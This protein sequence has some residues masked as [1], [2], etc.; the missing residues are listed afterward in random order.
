MSEYIICLDA[1]GD[2]LKET[3]LEN[4]IAFVPMEYSIGEEMRTSHGCESEELLKRFYDGQRCISESVDFLHHE[5]IG[6]Q[7]SEMHRCGRRTRQNLQR[8]RLRRWRRRNR[9]GHRNLGN[10][11]G[12]GGRARD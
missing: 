6:N 9:R 12:K 4:G 8:R 5:G 2:I 1:S 10:G 11:R 7:S 3:A